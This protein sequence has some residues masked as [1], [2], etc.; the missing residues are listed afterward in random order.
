VSLNAPRGLTVTR[1]PCASR[2]LHRREKVR[3][4]CAR[5]TS[6]PRPPR[7]WH[8]RSSLHVSARA[9]PLTWM[10]SAPWGR[11]RRGCGCRGPPLRGYAR[12]HALE[13]R[14]LARSSL[15]AACVRSTQPSRVLGGLRSPCPHA[16]RP[17]ARAL[18]PGFIAA[19]RPCH[20]PGA[21]HAPPTAGRARPAAP[22]A[23]R[24]AQLR[25]H[26]TARHPARSH[27]ASRA[28]AA[29]A[30]R[31]R[32]PASAR[33]A[34]EPPPGERALA[35]LSRLLACHLKMSTRGPLRRARAQ[36]ITLAFVAFASDARVHLH[37]LSA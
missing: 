28:G 37:L 17:R 25:A 23:L 11:L 29:P 20:L 35:S 10:A 4:S 13:H 21:R 31:P 12:F 3:R 2:P 9:T 6:A 26:A 30:P 22:A 34:G 15:R 7:L 1:P 36:S 18:P 8:V 19:P 5:A 32:R 33:P 24:A 16:R 27:C 14:E